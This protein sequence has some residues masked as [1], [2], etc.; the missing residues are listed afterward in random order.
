[1]AVAFSYIV[2]YEAGPYLSTVH[3]VRVPD[4]TRSVILNVEAEYKRTRK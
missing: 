2:E 4:L 1:M 3:G